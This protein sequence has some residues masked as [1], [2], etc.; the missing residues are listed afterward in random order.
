MARLNPMNGVNRITVHHEGWTQVWFTDKATTAKRLDQIRR[1]HVD[2]GWGDIG[3]HYIVDRAGRVWEGRNLRYQGAHVKDQN[4]HNIGIL[5]LGNFNVQQPS[6]AQMK[7]LVQTIRTLMR[8][9]N[10]P[11]SRVY[12]HQ[13]LNSSTCPGR[14]LQQRMIS[15]RRSGALG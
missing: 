3:Y 13:E 2:R 5:V 14:N 1:N 11:A 10:V 12:T 9:Y 4:E 7:A 8:A 15:L 6:E